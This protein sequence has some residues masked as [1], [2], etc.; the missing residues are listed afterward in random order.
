MT[1]TK[2]FTF[3][4]TIFLLFSVSVHAQSEKKVVLANAKKVV[5]A[6]K[7]RDTDALSTFVHPT[8]GVRFSPYCYVEQN[9]QVFKKSQVSGLM[10]KPKKFLWGE[11]DGSGDPIRLTFAKY[12]K[13]YVYD[14]DFLKVGSVF[15]QNRQSGGNTIFNG[16][17]FYPKGKFVEYYF[18][19]TQK[20]D[21]LDW[22]SLIL[23]FEKS[24]KKWYLTAII[25]NEWTI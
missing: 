15:Y 7:N 9:H 21:G 25:H 24:G 19:G 12:Y 13:R 18:K 20:Y 22:R 2:F 4:F 10:K 17:E 8:K 1:R 14:I 11:A 5:Q 6:L 16:E 3:F 23:V